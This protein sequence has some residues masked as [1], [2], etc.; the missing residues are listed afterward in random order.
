MFD[1]QIAFTLF[2][3]LL[4]LVVLGVHIAVAL[5]ISS[6]VCAYL[7]YD[8]VNI[9]FTLPASTAY[10]A[11]RDYVFAA[12]PL[13]LLLGEFVRKSGIVMDLYSG[14]ER[15][16][17]KVP[18]RLGLATVFG[19]AI[20]SFITGVS[21]A[22]T[23]AFSRIAY[24]EMVR[25]N[26]KRGFSIGTIVGSSCLGML[27]PPS[28]LMVIWGLL[29][30]ESVGKIFIAGIIPGLILTVFFAIYVCVTSAF[31]KNLVSDT[32]NEFNADTNTHTPLDKK[33]LLGA[34]L[35]MLFIIISTLGGIWSGFFTPTE[36]A[37]VGAFIALV[38]ALMRGAGINGAYEAIV[39]S[40]RTAAP[41]LIMIIA[42]VLYSRVLSVTGI[43]DALSGFFLEV[44]TERWAILA[45]MVLVWL[46]MGTITDSVSTMLLTV[47][48]F[49]P[50]ASNAGIDPMAFA[51]IGI[52]SIEAGLLSPPFG[53]LVFTAKASLEG[54]NITV[55]EI[56]YSS[57]PYFLMI[58]ALIV[59]IYLFP[60]LAYSPSSI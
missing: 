7:L 51:I 19:N 9:L 39:S 43:T 60:G 27:I 28:I 3:L 20:F 46:I 11:L 29:T 24:P 36:A 4:I 13:F 8:N 14:I 48:L 40:G 42:A 18:G 58:I 54:D 52:L 38:I 12:I 33:S 56:F 15:L 45:C 32:S 17:P 5:G 53:L 26:Y 50:I 31:G 1:A 6:L 37:A 34:T 47:P 44:V 30:E 41:I 10:E 25:H 59:L 21:I 22:S 2:G 16:I 49:F 23:A 57:F 35:G 55:G